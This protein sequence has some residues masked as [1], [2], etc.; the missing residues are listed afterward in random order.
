M[1]WDSSRP[2]PW[3]RLIRDWLLYVGVMVVVLLIVSRDRLSPGIFAGL[4]VSGG[5]FVLA[6]RIQ[7][8]GVAL[9][10]VCAQFGERLEGLVVGRNGLAR[11]TTGIG[12]IGGH[13]P[14][15]DLSA[16]AFCGEKRDSLVL[17]ESAQA[18]GDR[19]TR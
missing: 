1:A 10:L 8:A 7:T 17:L 3:T 13:D 2:V 4:F 14:L 12:S 19:R 15:Q 9:I 18:F 16:I 5:A 6:I 11:S